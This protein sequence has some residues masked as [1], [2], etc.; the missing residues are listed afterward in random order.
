MVNVWPTCRWGSI[1]QHVAATIPISEGDLADAR[2]SVA[3]A[4]YIA[5]RAAATRYL[6][7]GM[8][9]LVGPLAADAEAAVMEAM[10]TRDTSTHAWLTAYEVPWALMVLR[11]LAG[12]VT[13][14]SGAV[15]DARKRGA[16]VPDIAA[17][18]GVS[19][20][21]VYAAYADQVVRRRRSSA[22]TDR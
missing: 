5:A 22:Q 18:L 17:A 11:L 12:T 20:Q 15:A 2:A 14:A 7:R 21:S 10:A 6:I 8:S 3:D 19:T 13:D 16:T 9:G 4:A 1:V